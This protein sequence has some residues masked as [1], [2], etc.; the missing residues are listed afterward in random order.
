[1]PGRSITPLLAGG[2]PGDRRD[3][4]HLQFQGVE[5]YCTQR[6]VFTPGRQ[7]VYNALDFD[8]PCKRRRAPPRAA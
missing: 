1:M 7:Y 3:E 8:E 5:V 2:T 4:I 6:T